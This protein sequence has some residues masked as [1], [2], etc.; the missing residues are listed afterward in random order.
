MTGSRVVLVVAGIAL[1]IYGAVLLLDLPPRSILLIAVWAG[2]GVVIHDFVF[3]PI[4]AG[5]GW[6]VRRL[7]GGSAWS[8]VAVAALCTATLVLLAIPVYDTPGAKPDN[9]TA[10]DRDY[11]LGL[12]VSLAAVWLGALAWVAAARLTRR[13]LSDDI[14][15][16]Q[17]Q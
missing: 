13:P 14:R 5:L 7:I 6:T 17:P 12:W 4:A 9:P 8:A 11:P 3:A 15:K 10:L 1:G 2:A 16:D